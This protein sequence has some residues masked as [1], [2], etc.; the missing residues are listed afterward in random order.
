MPKRTTIHSIAKELNVSASTVSRALS[1]HPGISD[2][3]KRAVR[4][5]A[6][7]V[8]YRL[9]N[10]ASALRRG[11]TNTI[12]V[13]VPTA[14]RSFLSSVVRGI[15]EVANSAGYNVMICQ[16]NDDYASEIEDIA[17]LLRA[18]VDGIVMAIAKG[19]EDFEHFKQLHARGVPLILFDRVTFEA[20]VSTVTI[21]DYVSAYRATEHLIEQGCQRIATLAGIQQHLN[22]YQERMRGYCDALKAHGRT[23]E[24]QYVIHCDLSIE[25][26]KTSAAQFWALPQPPDG[27][28]CMSDYA[29]LGAMQYLKSRG[30]RIP[31]EVAI[32]GFVNEPFA[33]Y[34]EPALTTV[35]QHPV[36]MGQ[37]AAKL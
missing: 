21:D 3:T 32:V 8:G 27:I 36:E 31:K 19:T 34:I 10:V 33:T 14:D 1:D 18:Q 2:S 15:E 35:D 26:G 4:E 9:N 22:I 25:N 5:V 17:A 7:R 30:I 6:E 12:G 37:T 16:S 24:D 29:A 11:R 20:G 13:I 23:R 28:F